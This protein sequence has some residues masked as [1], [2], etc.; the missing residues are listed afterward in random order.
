MAFSFHL[1][2]YVMPNKAVFISAALLC[3]QRPCNKVCADCGAANP[4]WA[5]VNLLVV[6][7]EACAGAHRSMSS[8]RSKVRGL[9]L[10]NKVWTEPLIQ[11]SSVMP[12]SHPVFMLLCDQFYFLLILQW[13]E[14][15][16]FQY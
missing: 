3:L 16:C 15:L 4:E 11:V 8:N 1:P 5:S 14:K 9:K 12:V 6:I 7:C 2:L 13:S 10:D